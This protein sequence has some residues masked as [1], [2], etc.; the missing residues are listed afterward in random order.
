MTDMC[1]IISRPYAR[2]S[3]R[4]YVKYIEVKCQLMGKY[5]L[6]YFRCAQMKYIF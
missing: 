4:V 3:V 2:M 6:Y 5:V 1:S